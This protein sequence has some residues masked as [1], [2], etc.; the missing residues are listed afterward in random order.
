MKIGD[1]WLLQEISVIRCDD[2][3]DV[4]LKSLAIELGG[5]QPIGLLEVRKRFVPPLAIVVRLT[6]REMQVAG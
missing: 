4:F 3:I 1:R 2:G 5:Y 6:Q